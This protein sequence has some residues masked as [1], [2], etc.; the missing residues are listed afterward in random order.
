MLAH[1]LIK[2]LILSV[3]I[4]AMLV[5]SAAR[6]ETLAL[7]DFTRLV[8][9]H[10][11]A[12]VNISTTQRGRGSLPESVKPETRDPPREMLEQTPRSEGT[13]LGSG[14]IISHDGYI[15]TCAHV[16]EDAREIAVRLS[17]RRELTAKLVGLDSRT[18][19]A[20]LKIEATALPVTI[21][22]NPHKLE[23]GEWVLAIGSPFGFERSATAGI[24]SA[25][26]RSLPNENYIPFIQTD[27]AIN[28]GNS[29]GPLFNLR[30]EV[31]GVNSQIYSRNGGFMGV[32]FSIP[33]DLAMRVAEQI[34]RDGRLRRAWLGVSPQ[35]VT[36]GLAISYALDRPRGALIADILPESPAA[37][38]E[39][40]PGD[41]VLEYDGKPV[42]FSAD[43]PQYVSQSAPNV[44]VKMRVQRRGS[45]VREITVGLGELQEE[46]APPPVGEKL[47]AALALSELTER[48]RRQENITNG[49]MVEGVDVS[50]RQAGLRAGDIITEI[51]GKRIFDVTGLQ[52][53]L[54]H[55]P[56]GQYA[57]LRVRRGPQALYIAV[58]ANGG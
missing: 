22:G 48:Q 18:D 55:V 49:V 4:F 25:K 27:V 19:I 29:G 40:R 24:V 9:N 30:G 38:S 39:L 33:I 35:E 6:A 7:P 31:V 46:M 15:L 44:R 10:G 5:V 45:G 14:L 54:A 32:S 13:S 12:V 51:D 3:S 23:V 56:S 8:R 41:V 53:L 16:V 21:I 37:R 11:A 42:E 1:N 34:K 58:L 17:D 57:V 52:R 28:P 47:R 50:A 2:R 43:L 26:G 36:R 20:L